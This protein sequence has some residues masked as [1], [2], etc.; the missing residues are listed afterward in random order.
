MFILT[1]KAVKLIPSFISNPSINSQGIT[2]IPFTLL[3][4]PFSFTITVD[5]LAIKK[6]SKYNSIAITNPIDTHTTA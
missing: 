6:Y 4:M 5:L 3:L 2:H 1:T